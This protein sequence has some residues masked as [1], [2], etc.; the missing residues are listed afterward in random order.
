MPLR[1]TEVVSIRSARKVAVGDWARVPI[2]RSGAYFHERTVLPWLCKLVGVKQALRTAKIDTWKFTA[3]RVVTIHYT[4][5]DDGGDE[6]HSSGG[7]S[8]VHIQGHSNL[9]TGLEK[10]LEGTEEIEHDHVDA[11]GDHHL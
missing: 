6:L 7:D 5:K 8:L 2:S 11:A 1:F 3:D 4:L 9:V 10:A